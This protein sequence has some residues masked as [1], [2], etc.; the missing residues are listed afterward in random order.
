MHC[1]N[2]E[3]E[4]WMPLHD[5]LAHMDVDEHWASSPGRLQALGA[6][7]AQLAQA[8]PPFRCE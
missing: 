8:P 6:F 1:A 7:P 2:A 4:H 3:H 5:E